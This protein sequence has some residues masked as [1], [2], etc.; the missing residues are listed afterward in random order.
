MVFEKPPLPFPLLP[1]CHS[2]FLLEPHFSNNG[3]CMRD[4]VTFFV[5]S[6]TKILDHGACFFLSHQPS[7]ARLISCQFVPF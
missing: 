4:G 3:G 7:M 1:A 6:Y 5:T 2:L